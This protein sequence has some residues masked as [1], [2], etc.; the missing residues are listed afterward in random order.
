MRTRWAGL[1]TVAAALCA[2]AAFVVPGLDAAPGRQDRRLED[3]ASAVRALGQFTPAAAD[4]RLVASL[5]RAGATGGVFRFTPSGA[6]RDGSRSVTVAVRSS[7]PGVGRT[8]VERGGAGNGVT[9]LNPVAYD[10]GVA[11]GWRRFALS[12]DVK[13]VD[14]GGLPGGRE[15]V[16]VGVNYA[17][18]RWTARLQAGRDAPL[19]NPPRLVDNGATY[20]V[21]VGGSYRLTR[22]LDV[23]AG[24][25]YRRDRDRLDLRADD[26]RDSQAVYVGTAFRF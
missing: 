16:D 12:A 26:R 22:N 3:R 6:V 1:L 13:S 18:P 2:S 7:M 25:Q 20:S 21:D 19:G 24:V 17:T 9:G 23:S 8:A 4:P 5:N 11:V 14:I 10:L 15:R